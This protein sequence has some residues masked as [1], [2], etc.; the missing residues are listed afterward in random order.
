M[1]VFWATL[2]LLAFFFVLMIWWSLAG[3]AISQPSDGLVILGYAM[4]AIA[5]AAAA[6]GIWRF[7]KWVRG[8]NASKDNIRPLV[9][10]ALMIAG[11]HLLGGCGRIDVGEVGVKVNNAGTDRGVDKMIIVTGN[12]AYNPLTERILAF[13]TVFHNYIWTAS[14]NEGKDADESFTLTS[15]KGQS[16]NCDVGIMVRLRNPDR[17]RFVVVKYAK[18][19]TEIVDG[20][21]HN[22][23][24]DALG[25]H[26]SKMDIMTI[27]G[28]GMDSLLTAA[29]TDLNTGLLGEDFEFSVLSFVSR[30][31]P[32]S[33]VTR[34]INQVIVAQQ[35]ANS[36]EQI[37]RQR[38][39]EA[40]QK[41]WV[42][43][44]D[45]LQLVTVAQAQAEANRMVNATLTG[46]LIAW[47]YAKQW[48]GVT[49]LYMGTATPLLNM[50]AGK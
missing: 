35:N 7:T 49:P 47:Q 28:P 38:Q 8:R 6:G 11:G 14:K 9:L 44:G 21:M 45:S 43:K 30:P 33:L 31:R 36:A 25:R 41:Y 37:I 26:S 29:K 24:R 46:Q 3:K 20:P 5:L 15:N 10:I 12:Y 42:A 27:L 23:V 22:E 19:M 40:M 18:P 17:A 32:D 48:N 34:A 16:L 4:Y 50:T 1:K 39:A 2:G 13:P